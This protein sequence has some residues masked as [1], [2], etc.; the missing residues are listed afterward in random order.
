MEYDIREPKQQRAILK[1]ESI[2]DAGFKCICDNGYH[3]TNTAE[4]AKEANV[5]TGI[6]YQY[7][8]DKHDILIAGL[9]KYGEDIFFPII[10][11]EKVDLKKDFENTMK[12]MI[13]EYINNH[14]ISKVAHEEITSMVHSDSDVAEYF[15]KKELES[16]DRVTNYL[17]NNGFKDDNL[18]EKV[19]IS[20]GL[21]D[22]LCHEVIYHK[23][24]KMDYD[25]MTDL[26]IEL[27]IGLFKND[28]K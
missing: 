25:K 5:S 27:I 14:K 22:N 17:L 24:K 13:K 26:V 3:N 16:T 7:F 9:E 10:R 11:I 20:M 18:Q 8:K 2:I 1:K 23:H 28:I 15:Y 21:I 12:S 19:H 6:I 4:I